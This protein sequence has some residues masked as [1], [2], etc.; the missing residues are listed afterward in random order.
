MAGNTRENSD[1]PLR[2]LMTADAAGGVWQYALDLVS[3]LSD[4]GAEV[5]VATMGPR[6][7]DEQKRELLTFSGI[8]LAESNYALEWMDNPWEDVDAAGDWL[9]RLADSFGADIVHLN[10]YTHASLRWRRPAI[11]V[12]HSC[13]YSW[14]RAVH[15]CAP[16]PE[17]DE[18]KR[19]VRD[20]LSGADAV[21]AP[22]AY[23]AEAVQREYGVPEKIRVIYN[24]SRTP[25]TASNRKQPF[26]LAAGRIWDAAKNISLLASIAGRLHWEIRIAGRGE[27]PEKSTT[28]AESVRFLGPLS[29]PELTRQMEAASIFAHPALYEPF[30]LAVLEA[31][32]A[33]CCLV[34]ADIPSLREL[35]SGA[36]VFIN[37]RDPDHWLCELNRLSRDSSARERLGGAAYSHASRYACEDS[38]RKYCETYRPI[39]ATK[40]R[41]GAAA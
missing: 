9:L 18:Y 24:F 7:S 3:G 11:V 5:L 39:L 22:S 6:P 38:V 40:A 26:I 32:H 30:G 28:G 4:S 33:S 35:W 13:V 23:M 17:W 21:I 2:I 36:A 25:I 16:G 12:A 29:R 34:L 10:G 1:K 31:A 19:R 41:K 37:P 14:W 15:R 20:G 27:S 8:S